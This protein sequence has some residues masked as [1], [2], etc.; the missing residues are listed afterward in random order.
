[1]TRVRAGLDGAGDEPPETASADV[2]LAKKIIEEGGEEHTIAQAD[3]R[4]RLRE[5]LVAEGALHDAAPVA[6]GDPEE[7]GSSRSPTAASARLRGPMKIIGARTT[8]AVVTA[9]DRVA[10]STAV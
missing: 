6:G 8:M 5:A 4:L 7:G 3:F 1:M 10:V 2:L 9:P